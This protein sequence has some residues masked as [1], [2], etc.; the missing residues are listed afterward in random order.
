M[1]QIRPNIYEITY[2]ELGRPSDKGTVK[3]A[4]GELLHLNHA[5]L[6]YIQVHTGLGFE[7]T[8]FISRSDVMANDFIVVGRQQK[9]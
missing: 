3:L 9:A 5:D 6:H 2:T 7:P 1:T 8:F 4:S